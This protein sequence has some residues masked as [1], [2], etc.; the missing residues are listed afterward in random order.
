MKYQ[1][2]PD[3]VATVSSN[4]QVFLFLM[5]ICWILAKVVFLAIISCCRF[6]FYCHDQCRSHR[7]QS[8]SSASLVLFTYLTNFCYIAW[9]TVIMYIGVRVTQVLALVLEYNG[10]AHWDPLVLVLFTYLTNFCCI[11]WSTVVLHT[12]VR[13]TQVLALVLITYL[14]PFC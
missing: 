8:H 4:P 1:P 2:S 7:G 13:V 10:P 6:S 11:A 12:G 9:S 3:Y 5:D 14:S